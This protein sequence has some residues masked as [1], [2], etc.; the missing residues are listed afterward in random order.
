MSKIILRIQTPEGQLRLNVQTPVSAGTLYKSTK[1]LV[2]SD[3][4]FNLHTARPADTKN[5]VKTTSRSSLKVSHGQQFFLFYNDRANVA[6][7]SNQSDADFIAQ[8]NQ[9]QAKLTGKDTASESASAEKLNK[10]PENQIDLDLWETKFVDTTK[11]IS[12]NS[13][14]QTVDDLSVN[15]WDVDYLDKRGIKLMSFHSY[16]RMKKASV[17]NQKFNKLQHEVLSMQRKKSNT[18]NVSD[19][20]SSITLARQ[21][22]RH[23]DQVIFENPD[24]A[25]NF[26]DFW[27]KTNSQRIGFLYGNYIKTSEE[28]YPLG[29]CAN[30][31]AIYEPPQKSFTN[32]IEFTDDPQIM[33]IHALA[34]ALGLERVGWILSDLLVEDAANATVQNLRSKDTHFISAEEVITA[35]SFQLQHPN[36]TRMSENFFGSKFVTVI[37]S[38]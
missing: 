32:K 14:M 11:P 6:G 15:P 3:K 17:Q 7:D 23:V 24:I 8:S 18:Y 4:S 19:L 25:N 30:V 12:L 13:A 37:C 10:I 33:K 31:K 20:P 36:I 38:G 1:E 22:Y 26:I 28:D 29:I 2:K 27:R 5:L 21:N 9:E 35:A 34:E 16:M